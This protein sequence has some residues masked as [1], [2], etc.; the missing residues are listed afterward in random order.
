MSRAASVL[1]AFE[2]P[3]V[4]LAVGLLSLAPATAQLRKG[5]A[6][7]PTQKSCV[8]CH[9]KEASTWSGRASKHGPVVEG[10][11]ESCHLRHGVV[12]VLRL[13][14]GDPE[15][16]LA[17][18]T[19]EGAP[20]PSARSGKDIAPNRPLKSHKFTHPPG[21][22]LKCGSCHDPHGSDH[23]ALLKEEGS[24]ACLT[25]HKPESFQGTSIHPA[26]KVACLTCHDPHGTG[27]PSSLAKEPAKL[28]SGCHDG[29]SE[30][31]R[32]GHG[33]N[34]PPETSCLSCHTP[35]A[36]GS[37]GLMR[38]VVH[39]P[40]AGS[41]ACD[42]CHVTE[43]EGAKKFA[44]VSSVPDLCITCHEDPRTK[45]E[46]GGGST[47]VHPPVAAGACLA[48]HNPHASDTDHLLKAAEPELCGSCHAEAKAA[49]TAKATHA[50]ATTSCTS[51]HL[52][53]SGPARLLKAQAPA[54]C[55][56]CHEDIAQQVARKHPHPP[57]AAGE[58]LTC[59]NPHGSDN[60][61]SLKDAPSAL[62]LTCHEDLKKVSEARNIHKPFQSGD[63]VACHEPHGADAEHLVAAEIG[64]ACLKCHQKE[65]DG[66][67]EKNRHAPF[68]AGD[69]LTCH[70][71]HASPRDSLL[72][73]EPGALCRSCHDELPG[74]KDATTRHLPVLRGQCLACHG[75]HGGS[76]EAFLRREDMRALCLSC[77]AEQS[78][79]IVGANLTIH[80]PFEKETCLTCH[81]AHA[82]ENES[83]LAKAPAALCTS[84]H[85]PTK[86][87]L[88][89]AHKGLLT[90]ATDCTSC[91][92]GHASEKKKLLLPG[93]H[94]P[95]ADGDCSVCH[96]AGGAP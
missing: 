48:C 3:L 46:A 8:D 37:K 26:D 51:C 38:K 55:E 70:S 41:G 13:A 64:K 83:L 74:E 4:L 42:S 61:G 12:G 72:V 62:C 67:P 28:C 52:P 81:K 31:E 80:P 94:P 2:L 63:C 85:D 18:H 82:S 93:Q 84:C 71:P 95:F 21:E 73:M 54:L 88:S 6:L 57:A 90:P 69:C 9:S 7:S 92:A 17:C 60:K 96:Q 50:P 30:A 78:K 39:A 16:C 36:S 25:C 77:H 91:H 27:Q 32:K 34:T 24:A 10:K 87:A 35:H 56:T 23:P 59:H 15:L 40:M 1:R 76:G 58:C 20:P 75:P 45:P 66:L 47:R 43:G 53:H 89:S 22:S 19:M 68:D 86:A 33:A 44:L 49:R 5:K 14:A 11:C 65:M 79:Q 29:G